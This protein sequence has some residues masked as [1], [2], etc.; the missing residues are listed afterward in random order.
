MRPG[1]SSSLAPDGRSSESSRPSSG[2]SAR[3]REAASVGGLHVTSGH[4]P[5]PGLAL[6]PMGSQRA[7]LDATSELVSAAAT[8]VSVRFRPESAGRHVEQLAAMAER[9]F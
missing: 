2:P 3:A 7:T 6:H 9:A 1:V 4:R 8:I 5:R